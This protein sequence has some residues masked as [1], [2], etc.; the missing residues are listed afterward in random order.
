[1]QRR[2]FIK[3]ALLATGALSLP[4][5]EPLASTHP[6]GQSDTVSSAQDFKKSIMWET[7]GLQGSILEK[8]QA[9][10][11]AGFDGI[12]PSSHMNR[13]EVIAALK[14]TGLLASSVCNSKHWGLPLSHP[15]PKV[16]Q[17]GMD[18][19]L[20][21]MED[22][23]AYGTDAVLLVPGTVSAE[24]DYDDCWN[25][26][27]ACIRELVP[28]AEKM[29]VKICIEN[30]WNN[31]ILSPVEARIYIDQFNSPYVRSYFDCGN[32]LVYGWPEQ[33]IK[34]LGNRV[35]RIHIKEFSRKIAESQGKWKGFGVDLT[36]GDVDW[37][38]VLAEARKNYHGGWLT[39]EQGS[40]G[41]PEEL[42]DLCSRLEKIIG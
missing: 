37:N 33:W 21:A 14:A 22:A 25:R 8:C 12:E 2:T 13:E 9:I 26:S 32:I 35:G 24:V 29:Q 18:A 7:V 28:V 42:K 27:T 6:S 40:S 30:V 5:L 19:M 38:K 39:T 23:K 20:V 36:E 4:S 1:M 11:S 31:F 41:S 3:S 17:E 10:K 15:D 16:R 34:T